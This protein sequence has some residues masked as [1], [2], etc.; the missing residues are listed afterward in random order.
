MAEI[1]L[2]LAVTTRRVFETAVLVD[3]PGEQT[4]L[5]KPLEDLVFEAKLILH[6]GRL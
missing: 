4:E 1:I 5:M 2:T 6:V 3:I